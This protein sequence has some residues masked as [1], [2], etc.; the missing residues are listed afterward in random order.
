MVSIAGV[1]CKLNHHTSCTLQLCN[2]T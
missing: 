2:T 1:G